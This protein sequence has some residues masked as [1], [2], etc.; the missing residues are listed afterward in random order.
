MSIGQ[1]GESSLRVISQQEFERH[2]LKLV[3]CNEL[4][5]G[6]FRK[7][8]MAMAEQSDRFYLSTYMQDTRHRGERLR[9]LGRR[10]IPLPL[11]V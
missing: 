4:Q 11:L 6:Q 1:D 9:K 5:R 3:S 8:R 10:L 2:G 7:G